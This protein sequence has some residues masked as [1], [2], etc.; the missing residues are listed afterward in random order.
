[1][2]DKEFF[3][4]INTEATKIKTRISSLVE[5][6]KSIQSE[7]SQMRKGIARRDGRYKLIE[8]TVEGISIEINKIKE[9]QE[10]ASTSISEGSNSQRDIERIEKK[11][12]NLAESII[13]LD[14]VI[15]QLTFSSEKIEIEL[16]NIDKDRMELE[17]ELEKDMAYLKGFLNDEFVSKKDFLLQQKNLLWG[18][19]GFAATTALSWL[20]SKI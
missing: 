16:Q 2:E 6:I 15:D 7:M 9:W 18:L 10:K 14:K 5:V 17:Q 19:M 3:S 13:K 12:D 4:V 11:I 1:M 8:R 20:I